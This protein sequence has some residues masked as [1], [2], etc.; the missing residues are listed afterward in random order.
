MTGH[1][2]VYRALLYVCAQTAGSAAA[3]TWMRSSL[4]WDGITG[5][6]LAA[7]TKGSLSDGRAF[8]A[9][10]MFSFALLFV[11]YG[12]AFDSRQGQLFGP[13][14]A[15]LLIGV[16]LG[17]LIF[18][19][20]GISPPTATSPPFTPGMN[21]AMCTGPAFATEFEGHEWIYVVGPIVAAGMVAVCFILVPPHHVNGIKWVAPLLE[22]LRKDQRV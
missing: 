22:P 3:A 18:S 13:I 16:T 10:V 17:L 4:G 6:D 2:S 21:W 5:S 8:G 9:E 15:P 12:V 20:G 1:T 19:A 7:C 14:V 11:A